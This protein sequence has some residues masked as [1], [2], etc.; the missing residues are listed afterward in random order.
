MSSAV[1]QPDGIHILVMK[2]NKQPT[3]TEFSDARAQVLSDY[4]SHDV[5][6]LQTK[7]ELFL[8]KRADIKIAPGLL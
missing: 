8:G 5:A 2:H 7:N 3:P 1:T 4:L 6:Q